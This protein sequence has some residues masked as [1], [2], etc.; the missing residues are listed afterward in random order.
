MSSIYRVGLYTLGCKVSQYETEAIGEEFERRGFEVCD[1][2]SVCDVYVINTCTVTA[3]SDRKSRQFIRRA[4]HKNPGAVCCVIGCYSQRGWDEIKKIDGVGIILGTENK[5]SV[6]PLACKM[7]KER[8]LGGTPCQI[9]STTDVSK[10]EFEPMCITRAPRTRAYVKI[11]DGCE[12]RCSYCAISHARGRVRS[13]RAEDVV[14]EVEGLYKNGTREIVLT[15]IETGSYGR[16]FDCD[17][18]L[19]DLICLLDRRKSC[20]RIRLGSL[21]PELIGKVKAAYASLLDRKKD[22]VAENIRQCM[23]DVHQLAGEAY[24]AGNLLRQADEYFAGKREAA[25][26]ATSLTELDAMITQLLGYKD[27]VCRKMEIMVASSHEE[28]D[29]GSSPA[30]VKPKMPEIITVRRYDLCAVKR[31]QSKEDIDKYV[32]SIREKLYQTLENCDGVQ[33]N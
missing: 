32:E 14:S 6:V 11:E 31:L 5:M 22:V 13:K 15:G 29:T 10:A 9:V 27:N 33:I 12:S 2:G 4:I 19:A 24:D 7:L 28:I 1:F 23:Q 8:Q 26:A 25:K 3:E 20:E 16:D 30:G 21:A 18:D 17:F